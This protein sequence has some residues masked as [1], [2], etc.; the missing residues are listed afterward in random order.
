M[1]QKQKNTKPEKIFRALLMRVYRQS[2]VIFQDPIPGIGIPDF[3][4]G[5]TILEVYGCYWHACATCH[6]KPDKRM[7]QQI[8]HDRVKERKA[9][10]LGYRFEV[11]WE[12]DLLDETAREDIVRRLKNLN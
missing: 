12:H 4:V 5:K 2:E 8:F 9:K 10:A 3:R 7:K 6:P 1:A 11:F